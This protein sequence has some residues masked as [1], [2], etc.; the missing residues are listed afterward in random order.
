VVQAKNRRRAGKYLSIGS[1]RIDRQSDWFV[2]LV[3]DDGLLHD[4]AISELGWNQC[5]IYDKTGAS[6]S[7]GKS[8]R[9]WVCTDV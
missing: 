2:G 1:P 5:M 8:C 6:P 3:D 9:S 4:I 7:T